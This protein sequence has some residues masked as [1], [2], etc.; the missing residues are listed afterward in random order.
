M[1]HSVPVRPALLSG[2]FSASRQ[3]PRRR[4]ALGSL[5]L[6]G[7]TSQPQAA[8]VGLAGLG[9]LGLGSIFG[10]GSCS[11]NQQGGSWIQGEG[12]EPTRQWGVV[13]KPCRQA[14]RLGDWGVLVG[15]RGKEA[16]G[17]GQRSKEV[18]RC[19]RMGVR[20]P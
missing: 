10:E 15:R 1:T 20:R 17:F 3:Q 11:T 2:K 7:P 13:R 19:N 8:Q 18:I 6:S 12:A 4:V 14:E 16:V 5:P 9:L